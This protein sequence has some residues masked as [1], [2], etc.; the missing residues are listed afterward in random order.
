MMFQS[1]PTVVGGSNSSLL[2]D[3]TVGIQFQSA[4]TVVGGSNR[5]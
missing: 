2:H 1:A 3:S 5:H 4:P